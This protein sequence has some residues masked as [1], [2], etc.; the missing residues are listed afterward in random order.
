MVASDLSQML[1]NRKLVDFK[2]V[3]IEMEFKVL[4]FV[5]GHVEA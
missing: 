4:R 2:I 1:T 3:A 5:V